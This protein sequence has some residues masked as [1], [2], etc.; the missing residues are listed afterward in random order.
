ML[1]CLFVIVS[2]CLDMLRTRS[3]ITVGLG[4]EELSKMNKNS[5]SIIVSNHK[6]SI[7]TGMASA[8]EDV[9]SKFDSD[10]YVFLHDDIGG[11]WGDFFKYA[12]DL[13]Y[14]VVGII[15][16]NP[17]DNKIY[18]GNHLTFPLEVQTVD[19][20][21]FAFRKKSGLKFDPITCNHWHQ[22]AP[23]VCL[24]SKS[25]G[26]NNYIVPTKLQH[27][28]GRLGIGYDFK[29]FMDQFNRLNEKWIGKFQK[30]VRT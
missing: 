17:K 27:K 7:Y 6:N 8:Y 28:G 4:M 26:L 18:W 2:D 21:C 29:N 19:E 20:C 14:G 13:D 30:I 5:S 10:L 12:Y 22:Y 3:L 23:D 1:D 11:E 24:L 15:G 16:K 25:K 9:M